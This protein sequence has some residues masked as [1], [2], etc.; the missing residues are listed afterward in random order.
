M[1]V[2]VEAKGSCEHPQPLIQLLLM[3]TWWSGTV[4]GMFGEVLK[5]SHCLG[6]GDG[7]SG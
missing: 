3:P 2:V 5:G 6:H 4:V 1:L 7:T